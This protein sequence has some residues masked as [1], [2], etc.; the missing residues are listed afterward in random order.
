MKSEFGVIGMVWVINLVK[1]ILLNKS[2]RRLSLV[3]RYRNSSRNRPGKYTSNN[4]DFLGFSPR[5]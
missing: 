4:Q 5:S 2:V 3:P 1:T